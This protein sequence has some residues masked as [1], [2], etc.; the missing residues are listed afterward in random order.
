MCIQ[1]GLGNQMFQYACGYSQARRKETE[2]CLD[3]SLFQRNMQIKREYQLKCFG[4]SEKTI[5]P[6]ASEKLLVYALKN[7]MKRNRGLITRKLSRYQI[8]AICLVVFKTSIISES[9]QKKLKIS[10]FLD[11]IAICQLKKR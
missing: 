8:I 3:I 7:F 11:M 4:I 2:L 6:L 9:I 10:L 1:G 5:N